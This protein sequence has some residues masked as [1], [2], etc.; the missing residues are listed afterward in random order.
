MP[1]ITRCHVTLNG[2]FKKTLYIKKEKTYNPLFLR[3]FQFL[4]G[5]KTTSNTS[6]P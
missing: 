3:S 6:N 4:N 1:P 5:L 2:V